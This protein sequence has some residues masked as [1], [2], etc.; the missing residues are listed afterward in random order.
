[1]N[2]KS[3]PLY[4]YLARP[5]ATA[6][7]IDSAISNGGKV[8]AQQMLSTRNDEQRKVLQ[9][10]NNRLNEIEKIE[11]S[12]ETLVILFQDM[13]VL[14]ETQQ[15]KINVIDT[16]IVDANVA[17]ESG[18]KE[19]NQA[20]QHRIDSRKKLWYITAFVIVLLI[21]LVLVAYVKR[22]E[23]FAELDKSCKVAV[24]TV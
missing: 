19:M 5:D 2:L 21:V 8:F 12:I 20:I 3:V 16:N 13:Q 23:W 17:M 14:L 11:Q 24:V 1:V 15:E 4:L 6:E 22:C 9:N 7:D 10:V 18:G